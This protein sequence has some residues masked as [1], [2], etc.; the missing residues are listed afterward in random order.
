MVLIPMSWHDTIPPREAGQG[1]G[2]WGKQGVSASAG[3]RK[4]VTPTSEGEEGTL[5]PPVLSPP[6]TALKEEGDIF[7]ALFSLLSPKGAKNPLI[8]SRKLRHR[9]AKLLPKLSAALLCLLPP[10]LGFSGGG[11]RGFF[12]NFWLHGE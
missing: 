4:T 10:L 5:A 7:L 1:W 2:S 3:S 8:F 9:T 6:A 12:Q 11:L